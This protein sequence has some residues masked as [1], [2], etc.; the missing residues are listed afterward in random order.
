MS[1]AKWWDALPRPVYAHLKRVESSQPWFEVYRFEPGVYAFYEPGHFEEVISYLVL[2]TE[3]AALIDTG[4]GIGDIKALAEEF[5]DLPVMVVNTHSH[6]DHIAQNYLFEEVAIYDDPTARKAA[7]E[8]VSHERA[9]RMLSGDRVWKPLPET[10]DLNNFLIPPFK[11]SR[12]LHDGDVVDLGGRSLEVLHTPGHS[13]DSISLLDRKGRFFW[14]GDMF[15]TAPIYAHTPG[16]DLNQFVESYKYMIRFFPHYDKL[17]PSH[18]EPWIKKEILLDVLKAFEE[19]KAGK[20]RYTEGQDGIR[21]YDYGR[22]SILTRA[23]A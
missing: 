21:R 15:Y 6:L 7:E 19:V 11:V 5:T 13:S 16:A 1:S 22:F 2:G 14:T 20:G 4:L 9:V 3:K 8:G 17:M 10:F 12:W 18:N 23:A